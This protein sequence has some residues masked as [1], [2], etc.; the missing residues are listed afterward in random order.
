MGDWHKVQRVTKGGFN[1]RCREDVISRAVWVNNV[2]K[3]D[4]LLHAEFV[5]NQIF[6]RNPRLSLH[7]L[8]REVYLELK[9]QRGY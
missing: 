1:P 5:R 7:E 8:D 4:E 2:V 3:R 6:M 9:R